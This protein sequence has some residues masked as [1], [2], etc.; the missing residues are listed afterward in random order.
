MSR[1]RKNSS[2]HLSSPT[3]FLNGIRKL[4]EE[5][6]NELSEATSDCYIHFRSDGA[7]LKETQDRSPRTKHVQRMSKA[8]IR[9]ID[10]I[11]ET[12]TLT[13]P[14]KSSVDEL[15]SEDKLDVSDL[16][17]FKKYLNSRSVLLDKH[18]TP[19][20]SESMDSMGLLTRKSPRRV[21]LKAEEPAGSEPSPKE[22]APEESVD[23]EITVVMVNSTEEHPTTLAH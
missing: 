5:S 7:A 6:K 12:I 13:E 20:D 16:S 8:R 4:N 1:P 15:R 10:P 23:R 22:P 19:E 3:Q 17:L 11:H 2:G 14:V 21:S 18:T 9:L